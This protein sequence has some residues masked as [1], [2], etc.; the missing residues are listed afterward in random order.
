MKLTLIIII[1]VIHRNGG[2]IGP[3]PWG[4]SGTKGITNKKTK[5]K[6]F[7]SIKFFISNSLIRLNKFLKMLLTFVK[8]ANLF[9]RFLK[10]NE[11]FRVRYQSMRI[12]SAV[13]Y[14]IGKLIKN[15]F[16]GRAPESLEPLLT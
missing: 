7:L 15:S 6:I 1:I 9:K 5:H 2:E 4:G 13:A 14:F 11:S 3:A 16:C 8:E 12:K 10:I